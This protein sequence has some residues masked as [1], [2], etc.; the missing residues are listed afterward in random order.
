MTTA[1][2]SLGLG[3]L[4]AIYEAV[5]CKHRIVQEQAAI[6]ELRKLAAR[7]CGCS[8]QDFNAYVADVWQRVQ[9]PA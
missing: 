1:R 7:E 3:L 5:R 6:D 8:P 9:Q 2:D 4:E